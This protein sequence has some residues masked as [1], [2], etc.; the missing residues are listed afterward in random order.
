MLNCFETVHNK[1]VDWTGTRWV[2][3]DW[4]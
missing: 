3:P 1:E 2:S 4:E